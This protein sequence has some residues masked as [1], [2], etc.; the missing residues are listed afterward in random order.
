MF[1]KLLDDEW[2]AICRSR[3]RKHPERNVR[4]DLLKEKA[5]VEYIE[6]GNFTIAALKVRQRVYVGATKRNPNTDRPNEKTANII[7]LTRAAEN[8]P[9]EVGK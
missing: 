6:Q 7:A 1:R 9:L 4:V 3:Q 2:A 8:L 5:G